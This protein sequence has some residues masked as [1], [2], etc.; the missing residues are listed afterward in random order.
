MTVKCSK[1][2]ATAKKAHYALRAKAA[3]SYHTRMA[4]RQWRWPDR[5]WLISGGLIAAGLLVAGLILA[6]VFDPP[7]NGVMARERPLTPQSIPA[8]GHTLI[9]LDEPLPATN[10][11]IRLTAAHQSGEPDIGYGLLLGDEGRGLRVLV[12][13]LGY[14]QVIVGETAVLPWQPWPHVHTGAAANEVWVN[15][16]PTLPPNAAD[17]SS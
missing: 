16:G 3:A 13:P 11:T 5:M 4:D 12:S 15:V 14:A 7:L 9:W 2:G 17:I 6:G 10:Y 1:I 8:T